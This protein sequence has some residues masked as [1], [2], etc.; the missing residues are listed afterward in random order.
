MATLQ[1]QI[2]TYR[3]NTLAQGSQAGAQ[4]WLSKLNI[5]NKL[6]YIKDL[7]VD[8]LA[9]YVD[10]TISGVQTQ[11]TNA[12]TFTGKTN[13]ISG[14]QIITSLSQGTDGNI[15]YTVTDLYLDADHITSD[16]VAAITTGEKGV[17]GVQ[18]NATNVQ[19]AIEELAKAVKT[20]E[21]NAIDKVNELAGTNWTQAAGTVQDIINELSQ[22]GSALDTLV[23]KIRGDFNYGAEGAQTTDI[24]SYIDGEITRLSGLVSDVSV[25][26]EGDTLV[27][28]TVDETG[29]SV[30]VG[31]TTNLTTAVSNAN[32]ALQTIGADGTLL[33]VGA[34]SGGDGAGTQ[35]VAPTQKL[36][37]AVAAAESAVQ[38]VD[39][40]ANETL[41]DVVRNGT[42]VT[43]GAT[44][45]L[46]TAV[47]HANSAVQTVGEASGET[48]IN[49]VQSG[50][51]VT[52]GATSDLTTAVSN[53]NSAVQPGDLATEDV[54]K[55]AS[56][57]NE[58]LTLISA[59]V[60]KPASNG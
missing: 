22:G 45:N 14:T 46:T 8:T 25:T 60:Y 43:V 12:T 55:W 29:R 17:Q 39:E 36:T 33:T 18:V 21:L 51:N 31:A 23:D 49:V 11:I 5:D 59:T 15:D 2:S 48:L 53:A 54:L 32:S 20:A 56:Y 16:A 28:A 26:A 50:T 52:V 44:T 24:K 37:N 30:T 6:Y 27:N 19:D 3:S 47:S 57:S 41:I 9:R 7:A 13:A 1:E 42:S 10:T 40:A 58:T 4:G 38:T 34:K 35:G